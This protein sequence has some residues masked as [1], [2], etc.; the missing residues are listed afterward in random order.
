MEQLEQRIEELE[1]KLELEHKKVK[2]IDCV[3]VEV[4]DRLK[5]LEHGKR[6]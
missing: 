1:A 5:E 6:K 2:E 3:L 4:L